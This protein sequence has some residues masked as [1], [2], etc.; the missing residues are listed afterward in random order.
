MQGVGRGHALNF[1]CL[2][3]C[4]VD[5]DGV[6]GES[7]VRS[8]AAAVNNSDGLFKC[9]RSATWVQ[10]TKSA[11]IYH[12]YR[13]FFFCWEKK[14]GSLWFMVRKCPQRKSPDAVKAVEPNMHKVNIS[15]S[16]PSQISC[17]DAPPK[18]AL[19]RASRWLPRAWEDFDLQHTCPWNRR[20]ARSERE[21]SRD[22]FSIRPQIE[23]P[24]L[25]RAPSLGIGLC[26]AS[27][28]GWSEG[29]AAGQT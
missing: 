25:S 2:F 22:W 8:P 26:S 12:H 13:H 24:F 4:G 19:Y 28:V 29:M 10:F 5:R 15:S 7:T 9:T 6:E 1:L 18:R 14:L 16:C 3:L 20:S 23:A 17:D 21:R 27:A 11:K